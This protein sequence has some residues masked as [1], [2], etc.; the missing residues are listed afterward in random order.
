MNF[1]FMEKSWILI[2]ETNVSM[3]KSWN[4]AQT[5]S[6]VHEIWLWQSSSL[7]LQVHYFLLRSLVL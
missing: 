1:A 6:S 7:H 4:F 5:F 3:K 2:M